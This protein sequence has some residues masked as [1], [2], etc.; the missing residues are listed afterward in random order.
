MTKKE[1]INNEPPPI[2]T[3]RIVSR[4]VPALQGLCVRGIR[5]VGL[6]S[7]LAYVRSEMNSHSVKKEKDSENKWS[8][9]IYN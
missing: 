7:T 3:K 5:K 4:S 9:I 1:E 6:S 2:K 8:A